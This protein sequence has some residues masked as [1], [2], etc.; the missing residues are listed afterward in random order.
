MATLLLSKNGVAAKKFILD[1]GLKLGLKA[2][3]MV[4]T[5][6]VSV[7]F[8]DTDCALDSSAQKADITNRIPTLFI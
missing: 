3:V 5:L 7:V 2:E 6:A 4:T 1:C 8:F